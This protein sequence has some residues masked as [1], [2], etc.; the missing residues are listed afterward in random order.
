MGG[1]CVE[2]ECR[3]FGSQIISGLLQKETKCRFFRE[4]KSKN[5]EK[6]KT[7][8]TDI[9]YRK[10][11]ELWQLCS[12]GIEVNYEFEHFLLYL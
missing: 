3:K 2:I 6:E 12:S 10:R 1:V 11:E 5:S 7:L 4:R 8:R 9:W